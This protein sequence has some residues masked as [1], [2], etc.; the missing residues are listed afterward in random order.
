MNRLRDAFP[1]TWDELAAMFLCYALTALLAAMAVM[2]DKAFE[3]ILRIF[4]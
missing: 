2:P 3:V 1:H 4:A